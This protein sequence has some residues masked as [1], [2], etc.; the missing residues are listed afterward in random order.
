MKSGIRARCHRLEIGQ[1]RWPSLVAIWSA[2]LDSVPLGV[3]TRAEL[4]DAATQIVG[5]LQGDVAFE[6][7]HLAESVTL[8]LSP[9]GGG[10]H[11]QVTRELLSRPSNWKDRSA[12]LDAD[13]AF[14]PSSRTCPG[15]A[16][17]DRTASLDTRVGRVFNCFEYSLASRVKKLARFPHVGTKLTPAR[18]E[19]CSQ[20]WNLALVFDPDQKPPTL[21]AAVY[22]QWEW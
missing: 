9:E 19:S 14:A 20:S 10:N 18:A 6:L 5:F 7:V 11:I 3:H 12:A 13:Y 17:V 1:H 22:D 2:S 4:V 15:I 21:I 8:Y 16:C